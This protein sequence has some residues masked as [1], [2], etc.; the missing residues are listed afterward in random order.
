MSIASRL[1]ALFVAIAFLMACIATGMAAFR[2]YRIDLGRLQEQSA[3]ALRGHPA[4]QWHI[5]RRDEG[6]LQRTLGDFFDHRAISAA[7]VF[8]NLGEELARRDREGRAGGTIAP[9]RAVRA[10]LPDTESALVGF[11]ANRQPGSTGLV[12]AL[13]DRESPM[14]LSLP[15][16]SAF[17]P[18]LRGLGE[19]DFAAA[20]T[21]P[22][23]SSV[24]VVG[25]L[26]LG[27]DRDE[28]LAGIRP[29]VSRAFLI[30]LAFTALCGVAA[31]Q[32]NRRITA[33]LTQL[34]R[35]ADE[36]ASGRLSEPVEIEGT[37]EIREIA[38]ALNSV[39]GGFSNY[40]RQLD[41]G[42]Q[43]LNMKVDERTSQLTLRSEELSRA[44][45]EV[46]ETRSRLH[47]MAYYDSLTSLPNRQLF[48]EQLDLL[49]RLSQR[50]GEIL[51]LLFLDLDNFHRIN[52][53][54]G[55]GAGDRLLQATA[56]RLVEGVRDSDAVAHYADSGPQIEVSRLGGDEFTVVLNR[57]EDAD[58]AALVAQRLIDALVEPVTIEQRELVVTPSM[59]IAIAPRD[60]QDAE[61][62]L[63]AAGTA[64]HHAKSSARTRFLFYDHAMEA[65][66]LERLALEEDL[67]RVIERGQ[68][69]LYYQPQVDTLSG[70]VV[71]AEALLRWQHPEHGTIPPGRF[72]PLA[73]EM[74]MMAALG[75]WVLEEACRQVKA[76]REAGLKLSRISVN[77]SP[78]QFDASFVSRVKQLLQQS[79]LPAATLELGL[80]ES[81]MTGDDGSALQSL[82]ELRELGV[83][84]S[85]DDFGT[86]H[87]PMGY[88]GS[89]PL[90]ELRIGRSFLAGD[91]DG[92]GRGERLVSAIMAM[93]RSL[94]L[95][96]VAEGVETE[97]QFQL[98][99]QC[100]AHVMQ[101]YLFSQPVLAAELKRM[102]S[103]WH[104]VEQIQGLG[105][106]AQRGAAP[107]GI[108]PLSGTVGA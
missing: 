80:T 11:D 41:V 52:E 42:N 105:A 31:Q 24:Y 82:L 101:G 98:L 79:G 28:L 55:H 104:F 65:A 61:G 59:G 96:V 43:L 29:G 2:E 60:A 97:A 5:Y 81:L 50:N 34:A 91:S 94:G 1:S 15:V 103:P 58:S 32:M 13:L 23:A 63:R 7:V 44:A 49:L 75:D 57:L 93:A 10:S 86:S 100:G 95:R 53:S 36:V 21:R 71:G 99:A 17:N 84:L 6:G 87:S 20:L 12:A 88:L 83:C 76:W 89:Y 47:R 9:F 35:L 66:G 46:N 48:T 38:S 14:Q 62:L 33:P 85:V 30:G 18:G 108:A 54:L 8:D 64:M 70:S 40:K 51:A 74:G 73:E 37:G 106:P 56:Q 3:A 67:R 102:L 22:R 27:I 45:E 77:V 39:I 26:Q 90:D 16:F 4:L 72:I 78:L 69:L 68:L 92:G 107:G 19:E 25:Y